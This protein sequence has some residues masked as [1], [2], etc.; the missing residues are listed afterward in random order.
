MR[1]VHRDAIKIL[2]ILNAGSTAYENDDVPDVVAVFKGEVRLQAFDFWIRYPDYLSLELLDLYDATGNEKYFNAVCAIVENEEPDLRKIPMVRYLFGA[3]ES[4]TDALS[5][6]KSRKL[7]HIAGWYVNP[8]LRD[9]KYLLTKQGQELCKTA[10]LKHPVL[11]WYNARANLVAEVAGNK[12]G[13]ALK[14]LQYERADYAETKLGGII[15][16]VMADV[17]GRL[18]SYNNLGEG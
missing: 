5:I 14:D 15:P 8:K 16:P 4:L 9:K 17:L 13:M 10:I 6:L 11:D 12:G 2:Y 18:D 3:Y 7:I 1:N